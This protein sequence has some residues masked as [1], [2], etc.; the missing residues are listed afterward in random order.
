[1]GTT[2][3]V[4]LLSTV[5]GSPHVDVEE[6]DCW[7]ER[8]MRERRV[9]ARRE[10][11]DLRM[12]VMVWRVG[13]SGGQGQGQSLVGRRGMFYFVSGVVGGEV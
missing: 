6:G 10:R 2:V 7:V 13:R 8:P 9:V 3:A 11:E 5:K 1:M 4:A 12:V